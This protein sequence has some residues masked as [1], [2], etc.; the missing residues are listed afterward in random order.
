VS[1][2]RVLAEHD[3]R[4]GSLRAVEVRGEDGTLLPVVVVRDEDG[5][6][7]ALG[8]EC[9]HQSVLLSE[10]EDDAVEGCSVE[11]WLHGS[12]FDLR[13]G[14]PSGPPAVSPVPVYRC[15]VSDGDV[16]V[17]VDQRQQAGAA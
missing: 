8:D 15:E 17:D 2:V 4:P 3:L 7:H 11:C 13:T 5:G 9:S 14:R 12:R 16:L 10:G 1:L 6:F